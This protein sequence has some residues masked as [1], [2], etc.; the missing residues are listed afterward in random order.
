MTHLLAA[1]PLQ[2]TDIAP[3]DFVPIAVLLVLLVEREVVRARLGRHESAWP[4]APRPSRPRWAAAKRRTASPAR[5]GEPSASLPSF[6]R[7]FRLPRLPA[8]V[9]ARAAN[10]RR[11]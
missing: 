9:R 2:L 6:S 7:W 10:W 11:S 3:V 5:C 8:G 4:R 1:G